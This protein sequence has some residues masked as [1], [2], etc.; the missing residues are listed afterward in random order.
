MPVRPIINLQSLTHGQ[1]VKFIYKRIIRLH[2]GLPIEL[3]V[4]SVVHEFIDL[5]LSIVFVKLDLTLVFQAIGDEYVKQEFRLH[6]DANEEQAHTFMREWTVSS[7][8]CSK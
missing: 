7:R 5:Q 8:S 3:K 1:R 6:K 4:C 2:R